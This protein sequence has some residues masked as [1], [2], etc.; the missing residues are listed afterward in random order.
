MGDDTASGI[1]A[2]R[3]SK[4]DNLSDIN[5]RPA[6][7]EDPAVAYRKPQDPLDGVH[8][9]IEETPAMPV[10]AISSTD[11]DLIETIRI[12]SFKADVDYAID[13]DAGDIQMSPVYSK[14]WK[15]PDKT[16][17][18][19]IEHNEERDSALCRLIEISSNI[20]SNTKEQRCLPG[21]RNE[22]PGPEPTTEP[23]T[24]DLGVPVSSTQK[25]ETNGPTTRSK[26]RLSGNCLL[27]TFRA[28]TATLP[29]PS[30]KWASGACQTMSA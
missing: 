19:C 10:V 24:T 23:V 15:E 5:C 28:P 26:S 27:E 16:D 4:R 12:R 8:L 22:L 9:S 29:R 18:Q 6:G 20:C 14:K 30:A 17:A 7:G 2:S 3:D 21:Q 25:Q 13:L 11:E 1:D